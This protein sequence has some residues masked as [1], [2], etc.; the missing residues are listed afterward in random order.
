MSYKANWSCKHYYYPGA[1]PVTAGDIA[2]PAK[3]NLTNTPASLSWSSDDACY[4]G[5]AY[6]DGFQQTNYASKCIGELKIN[7]GGEYMFSTTSSDGSRLSIDGNVIVENWGE[8]GC[9]RRERLVE[10]AEGWHHV[11]V[12]HFHNNGAGSLN[13]SYRGDDT[14]DKE[15]LV[16]DW[17]YH[18]ADDLASSSVEESTQPALSN[19]GHHNADGTAIAWDSEAGKKATDAA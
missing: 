6:P 3:A 17:V 15:I 16:K 5:D 2:Y 11:V 12:E 1:V 7:R 4:A 14:D 8:H 9:R 18:S 10:L 19:P 13:V